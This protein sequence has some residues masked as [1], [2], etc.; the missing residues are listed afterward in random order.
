MTFTHLVLDSINPRCL[1]RL[2]AST[3]GCM[4]SMCGSCDA[5]CCTLDRHLL[6]IIFTYI[7][8]HMRLCADSLGPIY[9]HHPNHLPVTQTA[10]WHELNIKSA[11]PNFNQNA[12]SHQECT[13]QLDSSGCCRDPSTNPP[14]RCIAHRFGVST[15]APPTPLLTLPSSTPAPQPLRPETQTEWNHLVTNTFCYIW[16]VLLHLG[17]AHLPKLHS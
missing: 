2:G 13:A 3:A 12:R 14:P 17:K 9:A 10:C 11:Q 1:I 8:L 6:I 15:S 4:L 16:I 7:L 5:C